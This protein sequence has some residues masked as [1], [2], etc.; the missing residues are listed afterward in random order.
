MA[1]IT[2]KAMYDAFV[3]IIKSRCVNI[4]SSYS[5]NFSPRDGNTAFSATVPRTGADSNNSSTGTVSVK[6]ANIPALVSEATFT[7]NLQTFLT[8]LGI[9]YSSTSEVIPKYATFFLNAA[10]IFVA[11][12]IKYTNDPSASSPYYFYVPTTFPSGITAPAKKPIEEIDVLNIK[13]QLLNTI[14]NDS[15]PIS[16]ISGSF[17]SSSSSSLFIAYFSID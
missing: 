9:N 12:Q 1:A 15:V 17:T 16:I 7:S 3:S 2:Y 10:A 8:N 13:N 11:S 4:G 14:S 5:S 6:Y